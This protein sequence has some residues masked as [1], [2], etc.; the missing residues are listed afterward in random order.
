MKL[1]LNSQDPMLRALY[2]ILVPIVLLII[3]LNSGFLQRVVPAAKVHGR[4]Y[5]VVRY[6]YYYFEYYNNFLEEHEQ[7]LDELGYD[8]SLNDA[9][10]YTSGGLSWKAYFMREAEKN[11][12][13]TAYYY[14]LAEAAGYTFSEEE[15]LPVD[16]RMAE[17]TAVQTASNI[18]AKNYYTAY[19]GSGMTEAVYREEL[20]RQV[21]AQAYKEYL[22]RSSAP[23]QA[24]L[25]AYIAANAIQD[26]R[27][28]DLRV[29]TLEAQPDRETGEIG[30]EQSVALWQKM[31]RLVERYEAGESFESLQAA[32]STKALGD[33][34]GYL[35]DATRL[36]LPEIIADD[37]FF[38]GDDPTAYPNGNPV[39]G[40]L[41]EQSA[42]GTAYFVILDAWGGSGPEREASLALGEDAL[43][44]A[45]QAE[46]AANYAVVRQRF[47]MMLA[48][49]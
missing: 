4:S 21:K 17:H 12:A 22:V 18:N 19:Y 36:D 41:T 40:Y 20:T 46:I 6:N 11:M 47:G 27:T 38:G 10:Q 48:T 28:A 25:D 29:I 37:L 44:A 23:T 1:N 7:E 35:Y 24:E 33:S 45:A 26:Y 32:F 15:L 13:E 3:I 9:K 5:T 14:D 49:V 31:Q 34:R 39:G 8:P 30:T 16:T 42:D 43:L 2:I